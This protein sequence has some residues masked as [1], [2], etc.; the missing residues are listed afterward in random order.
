MDARIT[1]FD[2]PFLSVHE[3]PGKSG[4]YNI[5][6]YRDKAKTTLSIGSITANLSIGSITA[7]PTSKCLTSHGVGS[8]NIPL[9][10]FTSEDFYLGSDADLSYSFHMLLNKIML[11]KTKEVLDIQRE[12]GGR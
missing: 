3:H 1:N 12:H 11:K 4:T 10:Q 7:T 9:Y 2:Y 8:Y 6:F 5:Y